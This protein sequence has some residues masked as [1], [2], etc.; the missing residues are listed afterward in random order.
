M[1][2]FCKQNSNIECSFQAKVAARGYQVYKNIT[3]EGTKCGGKVLNDLEIDEK[4]IEIDPYCC[5]IKTMVGGPQQL[6]TVGHIPEKFPDIFI[7]S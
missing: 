2:L 5:S 6:K 3:W 1:K 4:A 7:S